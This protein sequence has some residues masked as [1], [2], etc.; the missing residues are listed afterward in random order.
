MNKRIRS[1]IVGLKSMRGVGVGIFCRSDRLA[2]LQKLSAAECL[3]LLIVLTSAWLQ[4]ARQRESSQ[5]VHPELCSVP[6]Q[7][8]K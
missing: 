2:L 7:A 1:T 3:C 8:H 5:E 4:I 6:N